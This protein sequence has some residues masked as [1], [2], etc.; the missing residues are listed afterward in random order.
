MNQ[1]VELLKR[2]YVLTQNHAN[3]YAI[4]KDNFLKLIRY[5][6]LKHQESEVH[7]EFAYLD[8]LIEEICL[9]AAEKAR[10]AG[11]ERLKITSSVNSFVYNFKKYHD[12]VE[13][14]ISEIEKLEA[15]KHGLLSAI[16][17][18]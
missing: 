8:C 2:H 10:T 18:L 14:S 6:L 15:K 1:I 3:N 7:A 13:R 4:R 9:L 17:S 16:N 12:E 11:Q 5:F